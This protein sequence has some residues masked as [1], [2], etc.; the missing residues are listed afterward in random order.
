MAGEET[1]RKSVWKDVGIA[2]GFLACAILLALLIREGE[3]VERLLLIYLLAVLG[4]SLTAPHWGYGVV[5]AVVSAFAVDLLHTPPQFFLSASA[6]FAITLLTLLAVSLPTSLLIA[7]LKGQASAALER[8]KRAVALA[9]I[10]LERE[11]R[12]EVLAQGETTRA[13]LL[14]SI[15]HDLRTPLTS[16]MGASATLLEGREMSEAAKSTLLVDIRKSAQWLLRMVEN[17]LTLTRLSTET[18]RPRKGAQS[19]EEAL[20]QA[21]S[22]VRARF[23]NCRISIRLPD[24]PLL[25]P[26]DLTLIS[27]VLINLL[28]NAVRY[29]PEGEPVLATLGRAGDFARFEVT[30]SGRGIPVHMLAHLFSPQKKSD[31]N[32]DELAGAGIGLSICQT[33]IEAHGGVIEGQ[34]RE[35][36]GA[37]FTFQLPLE[38]ETQPL[39]VES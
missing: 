25:A 11:K 24:E 13:T 39:T 35:E 33:I 19:A 9:K 21:V 7:R 27:Q 14:R 1:G 34:N 28:E 37:R 6:D 32:R 20:S 30:D 31:K 10:A 2:A 29:S 3:A 38:E 36:G 15:S 16:I 18:V 23:P 12:A 26:I 22:I 5:G 17:I 4:L 8:E